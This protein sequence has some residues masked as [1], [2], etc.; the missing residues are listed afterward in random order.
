MLSYVLRFAKSESHA[1]RVQRS[2]R[3]RG[4]GRSP[5]GECPPP[6]NGWQSVGMWEGKGGSA[7]R[8]G[9]A[10]E[11]R[12]RFPKGNGAPRG[13]A[14]AHSDDG[15]ASGGQERGGSL[16]RG[17]GSPHRK[18]RGRGKADARPAERPND[19]AESN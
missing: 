17:Q 19:P 9:E 7:R 15:R 4:G 5:L 6:P 16:R 2:K 11:G 10:R 18:Q 3:C 13:R 14:L 1:R 12:S 8:N